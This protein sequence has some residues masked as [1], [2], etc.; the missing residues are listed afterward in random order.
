MSTDY[1]YA[2]VFLSENLYLNFP[3]F[4]FNTYFLLVFL[5]LLGMVKNQLMENHHTK[6]FPSLE[7]TLVGV[8]KGMR[9][10]QR[11]SRG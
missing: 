5:G 4:S 10:K 3:I 11:I 7:S 9:L 6:F 8:L 1:E 2:Y